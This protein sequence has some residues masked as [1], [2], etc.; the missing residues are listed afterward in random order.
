MVPR[1]VKTLVTLVLLACLLVVG[2]LWGWDAMTKPVPG[3]S[4]STT[5]VMTSVSAGSKVRAGQ[6]TISVLNAGTRA[7]LADRTLGLFVD[8]GFAKGDVGNAPA[9]SDV[10]RAE[11]WTTDPQ[12]PDVRLVLS[13]LGPGTPV[14]RRD[15]AGVGVVVVVG[16]DFDELAAGKRSVKAAE[17]TEICSPP[18][19]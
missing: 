2:G 1:S 17:D 13:R 19:A 4:A 14:V 6:V 9:G 11:I 12:R 15:I 16:N 8:A 7:G 18:G 3:E 10:G 5:C